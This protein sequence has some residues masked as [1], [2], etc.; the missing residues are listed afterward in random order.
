MEQFLENGM[1]EELILT[2]LRMA[3]NTSLILRSRSSI[4]CLTYVENNRIINAWQQ[5]FQKIK[6][7]ME[8]SVHH[9]HYQQT[10][11]SKASLV[12]IPQKN[13]CVK[14]K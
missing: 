7:A 10:A 3:P 12:A 5:S 1:M 14:G 13:D 9:S 4:T 11:K 6:L 8:K 2:S